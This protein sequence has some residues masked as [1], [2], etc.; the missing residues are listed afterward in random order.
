MPEPKK[1]M[2]LDNAA[3]IF[4]AVKRRDWSNVFRLSATLTQPIDPLLLQEAVRLVAPRFPSMLVSLHRG[5]FWYYLEQVP[6]PPRVR[7][8]SSCPLVHMTSRELET[9][10][11]RV[12]YFR[13]RIAVEF[14]HSIT[15][16]NG[17]LVFLKTL[18]AA[19]VSA[20]WHLHPTLRRE[21]W[22]GT[23]PRPSRVGRQ[24]PEG[25][26]SGFHEPPGG[27]CFPD[28]GAPGAGWF[29]PPDGGNRLLRSPPNSG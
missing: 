28:S 15:D 22:I 24:L 6:E 10:A 8:D 4:P 25:G 16:G 19:Y 3:K 14:F 7:P 2:R 23:C 13:N 21:F 29:P 11:L 20:R 18:T 5:L 27:K 12:L 9:C 17:G 1:W 26:R